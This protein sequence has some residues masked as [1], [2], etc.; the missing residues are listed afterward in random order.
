MLKHKKFWKHHEH[1]PYPPWAQGRRIHES[2]Q[3][4]KAWHRKRRFLFFRFAGTFGFMVLLVLGGMAVLAF[5]FSWYFESDGH[6]AVLIW[7]GGS[8]A[9]AMPL[10]AGLVA[11]RA[12]QDIA[13]PLADVMAA[14]DAVAEGD[15]SVRVPGRGPGDFGRLAQSFNR[16]TEE[17][18]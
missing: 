3:W 1:R 11:R 16:M 10:L 12:F 17:L 7:I 6:A 13:T 15:L 14:A 18:E 8:L 5:L 2:P 9:L 4:P